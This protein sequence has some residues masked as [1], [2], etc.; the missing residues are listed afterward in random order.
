MK[1]VLKPASV[2]S[3]K[4]SLGAVLIVLA[5]FP[6]IGSVAAAADAWHGPWPLGETGIEVLQASP[7]SHTLG[8]PERE[9]RSGLLPLFQFSR[10][11]AQL[12]PGLTGIQL[13]DRATGAELSWEEARPL[14]SQALVASTWLQEGY[15]TDEMEY[16][17]APDGAQFALPGVFDMP[18][19]G[20]S[21]E[22]IDVPQLRRQ[23]YRN[24]FL[25]SFAND[26]LQERLE[27][28]NWARGTVRNAESFFSHV[29]TGKRTGEAIGS[30]ARIL[31]GVEDIRDNAEL[32]STGASTALQSTDQVA[33]SVDTRVM[34]RFG[35]SGHALTVLNVGLSVVS[36]GMAEHERTVLLAAAFEDAQNLLVI[37]DLLRILRDDPSTDP[38]MIA[39]LEDARDQM[40]KYSENRLRRMG[41]VLGASL[42]TGVE[43][44][45]VAM[46]AAR[47]G[48]VSSPAALAF[49]EAIS[50]ARAVED[51]Q[52]DLLA[53]LVTIDR[54]LLG[55]V[56]S[57]V[58]N[59]EVGS[60]RA[61]EVDL[62]GLIAFQQQ[63]GY[64]VVDTLYQPLWEDRFDFSLIG[65]Q[66][67]AIYT[68][69][70]WLHPSLQG[71]IERL[72][73]EH[74]IRVAQNHF[75]RSNREELL[76]KVRQIYRRPHPSPSF[77]EGSAIIAVVDSSGSMRWN[78]PQDLRL[79]ALQML[80]DSLHEQATF[81]LVEFA[82]SPRVVA[83]LQAMG[84]YDGPQRDRMR[85]SLAGLS[86][87]GRTDIR[88]GLESALEMASAAGVHPIIILMSDGEDN[89]TQWQ[90]EADFIPEGINVHSIAFSEEADPDALMRVSASTGG[91]AE[92]AQTPQDLQRIL[93]HLVGEAAGDQVILVA[94]GHLREGEIDSHQ[95]VLEPGQ[96]VTEFRTTWPGSDIDLRLTAPDGSVHTSASAVRGGY[97]VE[98]QTYDLIRLRSPQAGRWQVEVIGVDLAPEGQAYTL[99][100]AGQQAEL[101]T[102]WQTNR[103]V[104]A[105]GDDYAFDLIGGEVQWDRAEVR[106]WY[107]NGEQKSETVSL[108]GIEAVLGGASGQTIFRM[109][110]SHEGTYRVQIHVH[111]QDRQGRPV[112]RALDRSFRVEAPGRGVSRGS[113][114]DPFIRR[115]AQ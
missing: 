72:R 30:G 50:L 90:G 73:E 74:F 107:P 37:E 14:I 82:S 102:Q 42:S 92:I 78:D 19:S 71:E 49:A 110:P 67:W 63:M 69:K 114:L 85:Q 106:T 17:R 6:W 84:N 64:Q 98:R 91:I 55:R 75:L 51:F 100:V 115:G 62:P 24:A 47:L 109:V 105:V 45:S 103:L 35:N 88:G 70:D 81:G 52:E 65:I 93:S 95:V 26:R 8:I 46:V 22:W 87:G 41:A 77:E 54:Y 113:D 4:L 34:K 38:V 39:G 89:V 27:G 2:R 7:S 83:P 53:A 13:R 108:G 1:R 10:D 15:P 68:I 59:G 66:R 97:G 23:L 31:S 111:G 86:I 104:P 43:A 16:V 12:R 44:A 60:I 99:R 3:A 101:K 32:L 96:S 29:S 9:V 79:V 94:E 20:R 28:E 80:V 58:S 21:R 57:L 48:K 33:G 5:L 61:E 25:L 11:R 40:A 112:M 56:G 76:E 36:S 18:W